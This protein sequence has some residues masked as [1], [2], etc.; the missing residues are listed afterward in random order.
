MASATGAG[1]GADAG[2]AAGRRYTLG[3]EHELRIEVG[4]AQTAWVKV[5]LF[6]RRRDDFVRD[7][8]CDSEGSVVLAQILLSA[9]L[10]TAARCVPSTSTL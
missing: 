5:S 4:D 7:A 1:A 2:A 9:A 3:K 8:G 6:A 10:L